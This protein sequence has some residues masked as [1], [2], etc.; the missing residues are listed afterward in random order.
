MSVPWA[1]SCCGPFLLWA[2]RK[3]PPEVVVSIMGG[4]VQDDCYLLVC[5]FLYYLY[6]VSS[7]F[8]SLHLLQLTQV[9]TA[10]SVPHQGGQH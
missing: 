5:T 7:L 1:P 8:I 9:L 6:F 10:A 4:G 2:L 3:A